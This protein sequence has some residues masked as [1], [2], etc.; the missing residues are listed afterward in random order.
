MAE[1]SAAEPVRA[2]NATFIIQALLAALLLGWL[3][4]GLSTLFF[5]RAMRG[6]GAARTSA[7]NCTAPLSGALLSVLI[8]AERPTP[9]F[10]FAL[11]LVLSGAYLLVIEE[12]SHTHIHTALAHE[13]SHRHGHDDQTSHPG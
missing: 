2:N 9:L 5:I 7:L 11:L 8:F 10:V 4:Y 1:M 3:S 12:H 6:L 13:H